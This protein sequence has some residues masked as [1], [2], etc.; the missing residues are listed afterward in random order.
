MRWYSDFPA[1]RSRQIA[2]D[3]IAG[4]LV[5]VSIAVAVVVGALIGAFGAVG[6]SV[7][8]VGGGFH[9]TMRD[10]GGSLA[11]IPLVGEAAAEQA[12]GAAE[13]GASMAAAGHSLE[14]AIVVVA[15][16][17]ALLIA[18]VPI[19]LVAV[20]WLLPRLARARRAGRLR[21]LI[22]EDGSLDVEGFVA[23]ELARA[24]VRR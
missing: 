8:E 17:T 18:L 13:A 22:G 10:L 6:R 5:L 2:A 20:V 21:S 24:G 23:L 14:Q 16:L 4:A 9:D 7:A 12:A 19:A 3:A 11:G 15:V 1:Q